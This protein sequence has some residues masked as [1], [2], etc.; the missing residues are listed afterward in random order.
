MSHKKAN[1]ANTVSLI[2]I[3]FLILIISILAIYLL[4][5]SLSLPLPDK[6]KQGIDRVAIGVEEFVKEFEGTEIEQL[7]PEKLPSNV[8]PGRNLYLLELEIFNLMN[9]EREKRQIATLEWNE[10]IAN[11]AFKHSKEMGLN[12]YVNHTNL[13]GR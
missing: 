1:F 3:L 9:E 12:D 2:I 8:L 11:T 5:P 6:A 13:E 7:S 10:D 4:F